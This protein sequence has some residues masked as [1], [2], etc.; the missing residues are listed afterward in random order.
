MIVSR[1]LLEYVKVVVRPLRST[2]VVSSPLELKFSFVPSV[3]VSVYEVPATSH[4][5][6]VIVGLWKGPQLVRMVRR[7][8]LLDR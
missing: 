7:P 2:E 6:T 4:R 8:S 5:T 1:R 3:S